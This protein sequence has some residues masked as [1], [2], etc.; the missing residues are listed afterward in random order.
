M[1]NNTGTSDSEAVLRASRDAPPRACMV[2]HSHYPLDPRV[3]RETEALLDAG[4][5]VDVICI[6]DDG[7]EPTACVNGARVWRVPIARN[8]FG[9]RLQYLLEYGEFFRLASARLVRLH[10][11]RPFQVVQVH[12]MPDFLV[13]VALLPRM[14]GA[15]VVL[16]VHD[17]VPEFYSLR[18]GVPLN[19][20]L[21]RLTR[22]VQRVSGRFAHQ[23]LTAGE[24]F[25][26]RLVQNGVPAARTISVMN[27]PD[28]DLFGHGMAP[29][30]PRRPDCFRL[31]YHGTLSEYTDL[32]VVLRAMVLL[33][34]VVRG[35]N[36]HVYGRGRAL[37]GLQALAHEL[38][39]QD[40]VT[41]HGVRPLDEMPGVV[42]AADLG[43]VP[44]RSSEFTA[45]NY[46][47]KAFEY[48]VSGV[49]VLLT[50]SVSLTEMFGDIRGVFFSTDDPAA[51]ARLIHQVYADPAAARAIL[52][53]Q[54]AVCARF[55]WPVERQ[56]YLDAMNRLAW[57]A[58]WKERR[59]D[60]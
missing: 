30:K 41:F 49:P 31:S 33:Q 25:R 27:S 19:H 36:F 1:V 13:F 57:P 14:L 47:T 53:Q 15:R 52:A 8:R 38:G 40:R 10:L 55:A 24:P 32:S 26:R 5:E 34:P 2:V 48:I 60:T 50:P 29:L 44:Q 56:R 16:D 6:P 4:W 58:R 42:A 17:L 3:R 39:L 28:P 23:V 22:W 51:L 46:P 54:Q 20:R 43:V 12:N 37:P 21:V 7:E 11:R 9:S 59:D 45:L 35:L 18:Y